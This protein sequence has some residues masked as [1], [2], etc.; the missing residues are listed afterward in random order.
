MQ[1]IFSCLFGG[2]EMLCVEVGHL[3][4]GDREGEYEQPQWLPLTE[5]GLTVQ[6]RL[7]QLGQNT[8][9]WRWKV[10]IFFYQLSHSL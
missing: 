10:K 9:L 5:N 3:R 1:V 4:K 2:S 7:F 6:M 8:I